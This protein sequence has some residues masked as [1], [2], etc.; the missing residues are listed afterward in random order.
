MAKKIP[1]KKKKSKFETTPSKADTMENKKRFT[2]DIPT[3]L[4][5]KLKIASAKRGE[6]MANIIFHIL[7]EELKDT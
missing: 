1:I 2:I 6:T 5:K 3:S 7:E 4:H